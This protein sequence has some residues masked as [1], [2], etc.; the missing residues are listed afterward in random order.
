MESLI[1]AG[2]YLSMMEG[3]ACI[4]QVLY[5][6]LQKT[7]LLSSL[8]MRKKAKPSMSSYPSGALFWQ[9]H[10]YFILFFSLYIIYIMDI[11][12]EREFKVTIKLASRPDLYNLREFLRGKQLDSPQETI[13][14]LDVVLR[15]SPSLK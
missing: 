7:S 14:V 11:R 8:T 5:H 4:L 13:Q 12:K 3:R 2:A 9:L 6:L 1:W 15:E 10:G